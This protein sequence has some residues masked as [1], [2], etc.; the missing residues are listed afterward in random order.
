V[1]KLFPAAA[2]MLLN[3]DHMFVHNVRLLGIFLLVFLVIHLSNVSRKLMTAITMFRDQVN[4]F[5]LNAKH[6]VSLHKM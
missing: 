4:L 1:F 5:A 3:L 6:M 2:F